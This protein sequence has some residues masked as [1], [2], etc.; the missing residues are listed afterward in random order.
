MAPC[1]P[2]S[3]ASAVQGTPS[4]PNPWALARSWWAVEVGVGTAGGALWAPRAAQRTGTCSLRPT[5]SLR[6][7]LQGPGLPLEWEGQ[8]AGVQTT[9]P[10]LLTAGHPSPGTSPCTWEMEPPRWRPEPAMNQ[11]GPPPPGGRLGGAA[12]RRGGAA[13][14]T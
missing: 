3:A 14:L 11:A 7:S 5:A 9:A 12:G 2:G 1:G 4:P 8:L 13:G 6:D 10:R